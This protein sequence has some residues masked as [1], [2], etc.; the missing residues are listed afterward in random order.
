[1]HTIERYPHLARHG[2]GLE[3][4]LF[5]Q[6]CPKSEIFYLKLTVWF[7]NR[8]PFNRR[9]TANSI[10]RKNVDADQWARLKLEYERQC[11]EEA[12]QDYGSE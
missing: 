11:Y 6:P 2:K 5:T 8:S 9:P 4:Q 7:V 1:V 12:E 3:Q 10:D